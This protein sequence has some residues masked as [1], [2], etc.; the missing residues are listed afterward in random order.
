MGKGT[1]IMALTDHRGLPLSI[2][3]ENGSPHE[4][5]LVA[6]LLEGASK[7]PKYLLA[8]KAYDSDKLDMYVEEAHQAEVIAPHKKNRKKKATQDGRK[9]RRYKNRWKVERFFGWLDWQRR[10]TVRWEYHSINF[11]GFVLLAAIRILLRHWIPND[12]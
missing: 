7:I 4:S 12:L 1:K 10:L 9:L 8:D 11:F 5:K 6:G 3:V 2:T